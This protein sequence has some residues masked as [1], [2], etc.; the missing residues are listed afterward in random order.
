MRKIDRL[1]KELAAAGQRLEEI[2]STYEQQ[3]R[4][5]YGSD[6]YRAWFAT[7]IRLRGRLL[8]LDTVTRYLDPRL[9]VHAGPWRRQAHAALNEGFQSL[10]TREQPRD[11]LEAE[12]R[13]FQT[14]G[15]A[16]SVAAVG[17]GIEGDMTHL[18]RLHTLVEGHSRSPR[19]QRDRSHGD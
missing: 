3:D 4:G 18:R 15:V 10:L 7:T 9:L 16:D 6:S 14:E 19:R 11:A 8:G 12:I 1:Y 17:A 5:A 2:L 13:A